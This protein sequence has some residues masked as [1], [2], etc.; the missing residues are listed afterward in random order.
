M[1]PRKDSGDWQMGGALLN[2]VPQDDDATKFDFMG[3]TVIIVAESKEAVVKQL[4]QDIYTT[5][6]VWDVEKVAN[7]SHLRPPKR[8][9]NLTPRL[10]ANLSLQVR[11]PRRVK[12]DI[13]IV[14]EARINSNRITGAKYR[15]CS[16]AWCRAQVPC[17]Y[18]M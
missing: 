6:G 17:T 2:S 3:S 14:T 15:L 7:A 1:V 16:V 18:A 10:G 5:S 8:L 9:R 11:F 4:E 13:R 12:V